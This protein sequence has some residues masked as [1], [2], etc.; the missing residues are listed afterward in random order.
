MICSRWTVAIAA[1]LVMGVGCSNAPNPTAAPGRAGAVTIHLATPYSDDGA[2]LFEVNGPAIDSATSVN[3][4]LQLFTRRA[5]AAALVGAVVGVLA[6]GPTVVLHVPDVGAAAGY[7][8]RVLDV[9]DRDNALR[10]SL[11]GYR[12]TVVADG[13]P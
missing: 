4:S 9:A 1:V 2:I 6:D 11:S 5:G 12:L 8:A 10:P 3:P 7:T 13:G